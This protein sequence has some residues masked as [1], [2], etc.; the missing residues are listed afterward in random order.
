MASS[1]LD[2]LSSKARIAAAGQLA[3]DE[4][5][6]TVFVGRSKQWMIVTDR[7]LVIVKQGVMAG[8]ALA[9]KVGC[10][11][12]DEV[13]AINLHTG[14]RF[15]ALEVVATGFPANPKPDLR[16]VFHLVNWLPC[17]ES[18]ASSGLVGELRV[19][20]ESGGRAR[21]ARPAHAAE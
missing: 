7:Q 17:N 6:V 4:Q 5:V 3:D 9:A 18:I 20:V 16:V 14:P 1:P 12:F 13:S 2:L 10:F 15:A 21:S 19:F 11:S 8:A